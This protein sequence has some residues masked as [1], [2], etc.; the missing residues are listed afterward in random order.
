MFLLIAICGI[1]LVGAASAQDRFN[2]SLRAGVGD[3]ERLLTSF[4]F[5][6]TMQYNITPWLGVLLRADSYESFGGSSRDAVVNITKTLT[7]AQLADHDIYSIDRGLLRF[8]GVGLAI[9]PVGFW[10]ADS[11]HVVSLSGGLGY[12]H[13]YSAMSREP[14]VIL[15]F[16]NNRGLAYFV[17]VQYRYKVTS[18]LSMGPYVGMLV[19]NAFQ[20]NCGVTCSFDL[21]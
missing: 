14:D 7:I 9:Q 11:R 16:Y 12:A 18:W 19:A 3:G 20:L 13:A 8:Y 6:G 2:V 4:H 1:M 17:N 15:D 10:R 5:G 21:Q